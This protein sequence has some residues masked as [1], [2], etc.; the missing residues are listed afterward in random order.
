M[1]RQNTFQTKNETKTQKE[2]NKTE[3]NNLPDKE[4]KVMGREMLTGI[5]GAVYQLSEN[6]NIRRK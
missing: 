1:R 6:L 4:L 2:L 5:E 3:I